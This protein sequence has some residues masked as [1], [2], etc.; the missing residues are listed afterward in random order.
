[1]TLASQHGATTGEAIVMVVV[2]AL[3]G[4]GLPAFSAV[5]LK[6]RRDLT[7]K[8]AGQGWKRFTGRLATGLGSG[9]HP[10]AADSGILRVGPRGI[11][12]YKTRGWAPG[13]GLLWSDVLTFARNGR[14]LHI[15]WRYRTLD[16]AGLQFDTSS[17]KA[18]QI[19]GLA[20]SH[21]TP[22]SWQESVD[23]GPEGRWESF[24]SSEGS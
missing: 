3:I 17:K 13:D 12:F 10:E 7:T 2:L 19:E 4:I 21:L 9:S 5:I 11:S 20:R 22:E 23:F 24:W 8:F 15:E 14:M 1:M 16:A 6:K 18:E